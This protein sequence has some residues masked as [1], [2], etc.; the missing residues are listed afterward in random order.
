MNITAI[1]RNCNSNILEGLI[2]SAVL[3]V[4]LMVVILCVCVML[5]SSGTTF[6]RLLPRGDWVIRAHR[7]EC[8]SWAQ[9]C[10]NWVPCC[11]QF[12]IIPDVNDVWWLYPCITSWLSSDRPCSVPVLPVHND[13]QDAVWMGW[14]GVR[15]CLHS[16][17]QKWVS[18]V[19]M[20]CQLPVQFLT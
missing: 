13:R 15:C 8:T 14:W 20:I 10:D 2:D 18:P 4:M 1:S 6:V 5:F 17:L 9:R 12:A 19:M 3:Y 11:V 16:F 7:L